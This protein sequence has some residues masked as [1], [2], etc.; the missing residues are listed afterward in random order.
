M[1]ETKPILPHNRSLERA[2]VN[3]FAIQCYLYE[4]SYSL[5]RIGELLDEIVIKSAVKPLGL[6]VRD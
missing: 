5:N 6:E 4:I 2:E 3:I 1:N